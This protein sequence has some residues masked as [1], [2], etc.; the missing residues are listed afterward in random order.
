MRETWTKAVVVLGIVIGAVG[1][2]G[3]DRGKPRPP[4]GP[5]LGS[6]APAPTSTPRDA[7]SVAIVAEA[8]AAPP[9]P[10][11][12]PIATAVKV[13]YAPSESLPDKLRKRIAVALKDKS[14]APIALHHVIDIVLPDGG[15]EVFA[16]YEY[17]TYEDCLAEYP[18]RK[19]GRDHCVGE[20]VLVW[21]SGAPGDKV[22]YKNVRINRDCLALGAV[23]AV[24]P[25]P[26]PNAT[27]DSYPAPQVIS[28]PFSELR[29]HLVGIQ[30]VLAAD[31]DGDH[32]LELY[33]DITSASEQLGSVRD[34]G[35]SSLP[36]RRTAWQRRLYILSG[37]YIP[38]YKL[39]VELGEITGWG[40]L[41]PEELVALRDVDG[42]GHLDVVRTELA[43]CHG[44][45]SGGIGEP[46]EPVENRR[47][48]VNFYDPDADTYKDGISMFELEKA[49]QAKAEA[50][51][52]AAAA[53]AAAAARITPEDAAHAAGSA[54]TPPTAPAT[55][56]APPAPSAPSPS[57]ASG[58]KPSGAP[59]PSS[60][61][62]PAAAPP[63]TTAR[64]PAAGSATRP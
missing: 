50:A 14:R 46:C 6:A 21:D 24:F 54:A 2:H 38:R 26:P 44:T 31:L 22:R 12:D 47:Q 42:D 13:A 41:V 40:E 63:P 28:A 25:P 1:T 59:Q 23:H 61:P 17:G 16:L 64:P 48:D 58:A 3:C 45:A 27:A 34:M 20:R 43:Y 60:T 18:D 8:D 52:A 9:P 5:D 33:V 37:P 15:R 11:P 56:I 62:P 35:M 29:C 19:T 51:A 30:R 10:R 55:D 4:P 7:A 39:A 32:Q 57:S 53:E 49:R 36:V